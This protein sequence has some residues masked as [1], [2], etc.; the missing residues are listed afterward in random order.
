MKQYPIGR[1][2]TN[3]EYDDYLF[4]IESPLYRVEDYKGNKV[5]INHECINGHITNITPLDVKKQEIRLF[6]MLESQ[7][8]TKKF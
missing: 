1:K 3:E 6:A 2:W 5:K 8:F 7:A 4:D